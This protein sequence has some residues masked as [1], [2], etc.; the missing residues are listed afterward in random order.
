VRDVMREVRGGDGAEE[1]LAAPLFERQL[2]DRGFG[3]DK[4]G[5]VGDRRHAISSMLTPSSTLSMSRV[6]PTRA[7][8]ELTAR[9]AGRGS[10]SRVSGS[11]ADTYS[12]GMPGTAAPRCARARSLAGSRA[13]R[14]PS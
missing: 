10:A 14:A 12:A 1:D 11:A 2:L 8:S 4:D 7:A 3:R 13:P 9:S 6:L 5:L